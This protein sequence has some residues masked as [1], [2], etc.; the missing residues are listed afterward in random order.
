MLPPSSGNT[1]RR[2]DPEE[3]NLNFNKCVMRRALQ[4]VKTNKQ[5]YRNWRIKGKFVPVFFSTEH[6]KMKAYWGIEV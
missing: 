1:V 3:L 5:K 6:H 2:H 4:D